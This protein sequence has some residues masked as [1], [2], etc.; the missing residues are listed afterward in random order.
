VYEFEGHAGDVVTARVEAVA[1]AQGNIV[2]E[3]YVVLLAPDGSYLAES[4]DY[5]YESFA[6]VGGVVLPED[7]MY[8]VVATRYM[9]IDGVSSGKFIVRVAQD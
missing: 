8:R 4:S 7:G 1:P 9:G 3:P 2:L 6:Q 5:L